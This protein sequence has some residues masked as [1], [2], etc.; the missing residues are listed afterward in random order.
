MPDS[1][2]PRQW[3]L[4]LACMPALLII[5]LFGLFT[6]QLGSSLIA[7]GGAFTVGFGAFKKFS[8]YPLAPMVIVTLGISG[9]AWLG[10]LA[11]N[12]L[13]SMLLVAALWAALC[14][15]MVAVEDALWW[16][17]LQWAITLFVAGA[18]PGGLAQADHRALMVLAG[19][20]VQVATFTCFQ[21][22]LY[23]AQW[24]LRHHA[25]RA[26]WQRIRSDFQDHFRL[27]RYGLYAASVVVLCLL[28]VHLTGLRYGYWAPMTALI[29][30]K[31]HPRDTLNKGVQRLLGTLGGC[32]VATLIARLDAG[33]GVLACASLASAYIAYGLQNGRYSVFTVFVTATAVLTV[34]LG[35]TPEWQAALERAVATLLG[36][37]LAI[38]LLAFETWLAG[39][40]HPRRRTPD[41][42]AIDG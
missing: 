30:L 26:N 36:G 1:S 2:P 4:A 37:G 12:H 40:L 8:D 24:T 5:L 39:R 18:Y 3:L 6:G 29:I 13:A 19:G 9:S 21:K 31:L 16:I 25:V 35:G 33:F 20:A 14:A 23:R 11:G 38:C 22:A 27:R 17:V 41:G 34:A 32:L 28:V 15:W 7:L 42:P 10:S